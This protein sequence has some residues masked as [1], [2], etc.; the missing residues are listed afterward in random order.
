[1]CPR[2]LKLAEMYTF[3]VVTGILLEVVSQRSHKRPQKKPHQY[4]STLKVNE[5]SAVF[6][7]KLLICF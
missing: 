4:E 5:D 7:E 3:V 1:M 2:V 6:M